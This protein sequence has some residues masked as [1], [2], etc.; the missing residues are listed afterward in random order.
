MLTKKETREANIQTWAIWAV[1]SPLPLE[2][3]RA[4]YTVTEFE[5]VIFP[6]FNACK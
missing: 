6:D 5:I 3:G 1:P 2:V 4:K